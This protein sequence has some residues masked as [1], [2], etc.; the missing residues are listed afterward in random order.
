MKSYFDHENLDVYRESIA[1]CA[2]VGKFLPK[3]PTKA[4]A[5]GQLDRASTSI[6]LNIAEGMPSFLQ[7]IARDSLKKRVG[8]HWNAPHA[9][10]FWSHVNLPLKRKRQPQRRLL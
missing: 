4:A 2:C 9:W 7:L 1:F 8:P 3:I 6:P 10:M 5:K